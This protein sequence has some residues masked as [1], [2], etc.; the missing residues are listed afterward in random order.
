M[1]VAER[2]FGAPE[3]HDVDLSLDLIVTDDWTTPS[4]LDH[5]EA[6]GAT[7]A[8]VPIVLVHDHTRPA[9]TYDGEER[10]VAE[11][12]TARRNAFVQRY[13]AR[14]IAHEGIQHHVLMER[15][16]VRPGMRI[17]GNDSHTPTL[18][19]VGSLALA[20][21]P[22]TVASAIRHGS[23]HVTVPSRF[24]IRLEGALAPGVT[25]RDAALTLLG[26]IADADGVPR[27]TV[28]RLLHLHGPAVQHLD[29]AERAILANL[30][31]EAVALTAVVEDDL[32]EDGAHDDLILDLSKVA[33]VMAASPSPTRAEE[34]RNLTGAAVDRVFVGTCAGGT[35]HEIQAFADALLQALPPGGRVAAYVLV[36]PATRAVAGELERRGVLG[37]LEAAG[38]TIDAPGCSACFG[39]GAKRLAEGE[40]AVSTGNRN[41]RGRMGAPDAEIHL[42]AGATAGRIA[43]MGRLPGRAASHR[44]RAAQNVRV[45]WP[46]SGNLVRLYGTV[47]TDDL[48]P[49]SVP[50]VGTSAA[51]DPRTLRNLLLHY[52][53]PSTSKRDLHGT[54]L[55]ADHAFGMGSNRASSVLALLAAGVRAVIARSVAPLYAMG[56]RDAGLPVYAV[57]DDTILF[58]AATPDATATLE[59]HQL[60]IEPPAA[61]VIVLSLR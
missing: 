4:L 32:G 41:A 51:S 53:D 18:G 35:V 40:T 39:F 47:T 29:R 28:G 42:V 5:L 49:S 20:G 10:A 59:G 8:A 50:G 60:R 25:A 9:S 48:T 17:L 1:T 38:V 45:A 37:Q 22:A 61:P 3:G 57:G 15:N 33:P 14:L 52:V 13:G 19:A 58:D 23:V 56:A 12:L 55:I 31:P 2:L 44:R 26:Q 7:A 46:R 54:I 30:A 34:V 21:Q 11:R 6:R 16:L 43:A 27:A 24:A 36:A